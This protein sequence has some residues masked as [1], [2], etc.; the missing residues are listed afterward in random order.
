MTQNSLNNVQ[1][2]NSPQSQ[3]SPLAVA[4]LASGGDIGTAPNTVDINSSFVLT[5]TTAS[6][7]VTLPDPTDT[8]PAR[9]VVM[10]SSASSTVD[11]T[12]YSV[13]VSASDAL[14]MSWN[15]SAWVVV[16]PPSSST[17][18]LPSFGEDNSITDGGTFTS[19]SAIITTF[20]LPKAAKWQVTYNL[21]G[22][23]SLI[24]EATTDIQNLASSQQAN[25]ASGNL[26]PVA[27]PGS[28]FSTN[29]VFITTTASEM[30]RFVGDLNSSGTF[31]YR[32]NS[33]FGTATQG[34]S[35]I[36]FREMNSTFEENNGIT[37]GGTFTTSLI[38]IAGST[39]TIPSAGFW[40]VGYDV[41]GSQVSTGVFA[42]IGLYDSS[43]NL[44]ANSES[45]QALEVGT[46]AS[47]QVSKNLYL[48]TT[49]PNEQFKLRGQTSAGI[50]TYRN[51]GTLGGINQGNSKV[52]FRKIEN[53][54]GQ[55][56]GFSGTFTT[57]EIDITGSDFRIP[58]AGT[59]LVT[60]NL[61]GSSSGNGDNA[62]VA[63]FDSSNTKVPN[64][65]SNLTTYSAAAAGDMGFGN[66]VFITTTGGADYKLRGE[67]TAGTCTFTN[68]SYVTWEKL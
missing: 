64:C 47:E 23:S 18:T 46:V 31:T 55:N 26:T 68:K 22:N 54:F 34:N 6:Q 49:E 1:S 45:E 27:I 4:N 25:S 7:D 12:F 15:G 29:T 39:I 48:T 38:D 30:F 19:A 35:K 59:W 8:S 63:I 3:I 16:S 5:Q 50:Y 42:T 56:S 52:W 2:P 51:S 58:S 9:L 53:A 10:Q 28:S 61:T 13:T 62:A 33:T 17:P 57:T 11:F 60:Y 40:E 65:T 67:T 20:T 66:A 37:N 32:N 24:R 41:F 36:L 21:Y 14:S 44:I 43:N